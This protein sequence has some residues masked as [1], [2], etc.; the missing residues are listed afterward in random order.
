MHS[1]YKKMRLVV[2]MIID[3]S[4]VDVA[5]YLKNALRE[6]YEGCC[7]I[8]EGYVRTGSVQYVS[9]SSGVIEGAF[10]KYNATFDCDVFVICEG[11]TIVG[12]VFSVTTGG[13]HFRSVDENPSPFDGFIVSTKGVEGAIIN[14][15]VDGVRVGLEDTNIQCVCTLLRNKA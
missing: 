9:H 2:P 11:D 15:R 6:K 13:I 8:C 3:F 7:S 4:V 12:R 5:E 1:Q 10:V 14:A